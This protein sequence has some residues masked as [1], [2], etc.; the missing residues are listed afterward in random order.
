MKI[1]D[2]TPDRLDFHTDLAIADAMRAFDRHVDI[3]FT[4]HET[5][6]SH[7]TWQATVGGY[8]GV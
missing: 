2:L 7:V 8:G 3:A 5:E 6:V 1:R 4:F